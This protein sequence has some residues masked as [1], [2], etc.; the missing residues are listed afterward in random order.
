MVVGDT[1]NLMILMTMNKMLKKLLSQSSYWIINKDLTRELGL[2]TSL[3]LTYLID[4][5]DMLN[6]PFYRQKE[7]IMKDIGITD[8]SWRLSMKLLQERN[9][10]IV[11]KK[12]NPAR[13]YYTIVEGELLKIFN[14]RLTSDVEINT[15]SDVEINTTNKVIN[16]INNNNNSEATNTEGGGT[17]EKS[18]TTSSVL[19]LQDG[20]W[21]KVYSLFP[22]NKKKNYGNAL[23][24]W[25]GLSQSE[26]KQ[27]IRHLTMYIKNTET[28]FIKQIDKYFNEGLWKNMKPKVDNEIGTIKNKFI[29]YNLILF[30]QEVAG[31]ETWDEAYSDFVKLTNEDKLLIKKT[32]DN[33]RK[34]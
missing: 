12:G 13:N 2:E 8:H 21:E 4:C 6:Q 19:S 20:G 16:K 17:I 24:V 30:F 3:L 25:S 34:K 14:N 31:F 22:D 26:K 15:T 9:I 29:D 23:I 32:Y 7:K 27:V 5:A 10:L 28:Q 11:E 1:S 33:E 18:P